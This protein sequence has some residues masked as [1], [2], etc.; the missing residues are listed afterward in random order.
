[1]TAQAANPEADRHQVGV[2][3]AQ[4]NELVVHF[5]STPRSTPAAQ[6]KRSFLRRTAEKIWN[7]I[8]WVFKILVGLAL[9]MFNSTFFAVGFVVGLIFNKQI[10][11]AVDKIKLVWKKQSIAVGVLIAVGAFLALPVTLAGAATLYGAVIGSKLS[12]EAE[13]AH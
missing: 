6:D 11:P 9:F 2:P 5:A 12:A 3:Q 10:Q 7:A 1:M 13:E 4:P 8:Q